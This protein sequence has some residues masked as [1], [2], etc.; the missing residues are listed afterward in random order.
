[1]RI[2]HINEDGV[3]FAAITG[4]KTLAADTGSGHAGPA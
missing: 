3:D 4:E 1:V 2:E